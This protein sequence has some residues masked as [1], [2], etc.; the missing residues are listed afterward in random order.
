[1]NPSGAQLTLIAKFDPWNSGLCTCPPK[2]TLNPYTGCDHSCIYC[3]AAGYIPKFFACRPKKNLISRLRKEALRLKG[4]VVSLSNSSDPYPTIE[5]E[6]RLTRD[7]L[8]V[9]SEQDCKIQ[10]ITKSDLVVRDIDLLAKVPSVVSVTI[11]TDDDTI[12]GSIEPRAPPPSARLKAV[13]ALTSNNVPVTVR[14]DPIIP[15]V[16]DHLDSLFEKLALLDVKQVT[17]ST[18]KIDRKIFNR[19]EARLPE[20]AAKLE[21]LYFGQGERV[22]RYVHLSKSMRLQILERVKDLAEK[23]HLKFGVCREG[24]SYLNTATCDGS[25]LLRT[26]GESRSGNPVCAQTSL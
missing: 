6:A 11:T 26:K 12:A 18:L 5:A 15:S 4:E 16:N 1:M 7:C 22:G 3:Y 21:L 17:V 8:R 13:E 23:H 9:L 14:I 20:M 25:W 10:I 2:L 19:I 24:L